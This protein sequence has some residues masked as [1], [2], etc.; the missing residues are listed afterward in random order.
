MKKMFLS[1]LVA[2]SS[3]FAM[4]T[5]DVFLKNFNPVS[6]GILYIGDIVDY[7]NGGIVVGKGE[8]SADG[9]Y[10]AAFKTLNTT[11]LY[12][13]S[14]VRKIELAE[15]YK[16][17]CKRFAAASAGE[18][19]EI[20][21]PTELP[22]KNGTKVKFGTSE[23]FGSK[24]CANIPTYL[25]KGEKEASL[26]MFKMCFTPSIMFKDKGVPNIEDY[27]KWDGTSEGKMKYL[28]DLST[29]IESW[30]TIIKADFNTLWEDRGEA[31]KRY[32]L[33]EVANYGRDISRLGDFMSSDGYYLFSVLPNPATRDLTIKIAGEQ[34][35]YDLE[36]KPEV[37]SLL[38]TILTDATSNV[39][40]VYGCQPSIDNPDVKFGMIDVMYGTKTVMSLLAPTVDERGF[41]VCE[42]SR[43]GKTYSIKEFMDL[44]QRAI[45][46]SKP[47]IVK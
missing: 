45:Y 16:T 21:I 3:I 24:N 5:V 46:A 27:V 14:E 34:M 42:T 7:N 39:Y 6:N 43:I 17:D 12:G 38:D 4:D 33:A 36:L 32:E 2:T 18:N 10:I 47:A 23:Y 29:A 25:G 19:Y 9:T 44:N 8:C 40:G 26:V 20:I 13:G 22:L 37:K 30:N 11:T 41:P 1:L 15:P 28:K 31:R 35:K